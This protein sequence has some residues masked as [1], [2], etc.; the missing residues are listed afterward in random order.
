MWE[1]RRRALSALGSFAGFATAAEFIPLLLAR[2]AS[3]QL[4]RNRR[5][6]PSPKSEGGRTEFDT[7]SDNKPAQQ[8]VQY[9]SVLRADVEK[10][11]SMANELKD[12]VVHI[13]PH[14]TLSIAFLKKTEAIE[15]L[16]KQIRGHAIG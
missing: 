2:C 12:Q 10:L 7:A 1:A 16:A 4:P 8:N 6:P 3:A 15:K 11:C 5:V 9:Q 13:N 14:D